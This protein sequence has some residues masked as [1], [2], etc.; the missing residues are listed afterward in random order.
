MILG[1]F[2]SASGDCAMRGG[3]SCDMFDPAF[4]YA[5]TTS[6]ADPAIRGACDTL[7]TTRAPASVTKTILEAQKRNAEA[8]FVIPMVGFVPASVTND[9]WATY[10]PNAIGLL[11]SVALA[12]LATHFHRRWPDHS[13]RL[14]MLALS[15]SPDCRNRKGQFRPGAR[16]RSSALVG[17]RAPNAAA[18][19]LGRNDLSGSGRLAG[20]S[21]APLAHSR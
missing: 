16:R 17:G 3:A 15:S 19:G 13:I 1:L 12:L 2:A 20:S 14:A 5:A 11:V 21:V 18:S 6:T 8:V 10:C 7:A 4:G 9:T